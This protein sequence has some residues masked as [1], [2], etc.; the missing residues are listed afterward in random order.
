M[1]N[2]S[3]AI[4]VLCISFVLP[5]AECDLQMT[6]EEKGY[7]SSITF[8]GMLIGGYIWGA[9]SDSTGR[10]YSLISSLVFNGVSSILAGFAP[11]YTWLF[12]FRLLSGIG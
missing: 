6:T 11:N 7:L 4:E 10:K 8:V 12:I 9:L 3:D 5:S 1:A 2:A